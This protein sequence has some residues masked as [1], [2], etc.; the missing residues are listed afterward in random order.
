MQDSATLAQWSGV[1]AERTVIIMPNA[2][3]TDLAHVQPHHLAALHSPPHKPALSGLKGLP[4]RV[5]S[6][7]KDGD[8]CSAVSACCLHVTCGDGDCVLG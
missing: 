7:A 8:V 2:D 1:E 6:A 3:V 5:S 4:A